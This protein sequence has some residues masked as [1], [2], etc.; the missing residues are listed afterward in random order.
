M[1]DDA[2]QREI[3][4]DDRRLRA[5]LIAVPGVLDLEAEGF[6][7][8][9]TLMGNVDLAASWSPDHL[10]WV[11]DT[12]YEV[13][14]DE[15]VEDLTPGFQDGRLFMVRSPWPSID[16]DTV[17]KLMFRWLSRNKSRYAYDVTQY[18]YRA[19][20]AAQLTVVEEFFRQSEAWVRAYSRG[21][22]NRL[23]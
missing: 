9:E 6:T 19:D 1:A 20:K 5:A 2:L 23:Q 14:P 16:L 7:A 11:R 15:D 3:G 21:R 4:E 10:R 8:I 12:R 22:I 17:I 18:G 13:D